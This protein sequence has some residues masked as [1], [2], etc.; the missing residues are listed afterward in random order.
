[1][2][3]DSVFQHVKNIQYVRPLLYLG[4]LE[5]EISVSKKKPLKTSRLLPCVSI[6]R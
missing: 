2:R 6:K 1:M 4:L 5:N 3:S